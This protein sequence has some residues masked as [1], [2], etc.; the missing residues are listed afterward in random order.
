MIVIN[1]DGVTSEV[2]KAMMDVAAATLNPYCTVSWFDENRN[3]QGPYRR[4]LIENTFTQLSGT[5]A[6]AWRSG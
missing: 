1:N 2:L 3:V 5:A 6:W 4:P